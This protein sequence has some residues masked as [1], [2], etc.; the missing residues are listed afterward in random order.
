M[1][2]YVLDDIVPRAL[3][4]ITGGRV[5]NCPNFPPIGYIPKM[6]FCGGRGGGGIMPFWGWRGACIPFGDINPVAAILL[7]IPFGRFIMLCCVIR[8]VGRV[9]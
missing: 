9:V 4:A 7:A 3:L 8:I 6:P 1:G 5:G 2:V